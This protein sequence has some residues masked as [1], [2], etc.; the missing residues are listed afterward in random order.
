MRRHSVND[1]ELRPRECEIDHLKLAWI[2]RFR[3]S[4]QLLGGIVGAGILP[5][6]DNLRVV[7]R[8]PVYLDWGS[9]G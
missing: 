3:H 2:G 8:R 7:E 5:N 4:Q 1:R 9:R 6:R